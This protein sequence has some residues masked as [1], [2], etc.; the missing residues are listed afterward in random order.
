[1][2]KK[3]H[4]KQ[5]RLKAVYWLFDR[6]T[7]LRRSSLRVTPQNIHV[8]VLKNKSYI[9]PKW[10]TA[11]LF[12]NH[13]I[14]VV[15]VSPNLRWLRKLFVNWPEFKFRAWLPNGSR[16]N[17]PSDRP[18]VFAGA[19]GQWLKWLHF[20]CWWR[21]LWMRSIDCRSSIKQNCKNAYQWPINLPRLHWI[22]WSQWKFH[23]FPES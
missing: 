22:R 7:F 12:E 8:F 6:Q 14:Y 17:C 15:L 13:A 18:F 21:F 9:L 23:S 20:C 16:C 10:N 19:A 4:R 3:A 2:N 5:K 1:M 11:P